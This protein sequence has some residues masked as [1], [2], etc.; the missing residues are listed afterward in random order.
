MGKNN[1]EAEEIQTK[2]NEIRETGLHSANFEQ[3][4]EGERGKVGEKATETIYR[5]E[6]RL[7]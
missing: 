5:A 7:G 3:I 4:R 2:K 6:V 1:V